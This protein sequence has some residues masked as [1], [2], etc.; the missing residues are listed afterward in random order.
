MQNVIFNNENFRYSDKILSKT[1]ASF[2]KI[3]VALFTF[4]LIISELCTAWKVSK[5]GVFSGPY[6]PAFGLN[7]DQKKLCIWT[8]FTQ[9]CSSKIQF[10]QKTGKHEDIIFNTR[11]SIAWNEFK[12]IVI[13]IQIIFSNSKVQKK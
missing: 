3:S 11:L 7:T 12:C 9:R 6:F 13:D 1:T 4:F 2:L 10:L 5:Y 8:H